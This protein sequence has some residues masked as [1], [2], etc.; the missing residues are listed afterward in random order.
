MRAMGGAIVAA[1]AATLAACGTTMQRTALI[2][3][4]YLKREPDNK[5]A[6]RGV[7]Y[8]LPSTVLPIRITG[9][10]KLIR[11]EKNPTAKHY[12]YL[13]SMSILPTK[14]VPDTSAQMLLEYLPEAASDDEFR[15]SVTQDGLLTSA[16]AKSTDRSKDVV[17]KLVEL[18]A[19]V[20]KGVS[21]EET[22][23]DDERRK[24]CYE[25]LQTVSIDW[26]VN[27][28]NALL[29]KPNAGNQIIK[30]STDALNET[31]LA[32]MRRK[33]VESGEKKSPV[34][35]TIAEGPKSATKHKVGTPDGVVFRAMTS[36]EVTATLNADGLAFSDTKHVVP[37]T[38]VSGAQIAVTQVMAADPGQTFVID[39][40]RT[41][42][43]PKRVDL[44]I[45]DGVLTGT[46][47]DKPSELL[48]GF[49]LPV[50]VL[51]AIV[52]IPAELLNFKITEMKAETGLTT[53]EVNA[54][55]AEIELLKQQQA[56]EALKQ[57]IENSRQPPQ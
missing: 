14:Q 3:T 35:M 48:A 50:E 33:T 20:M 29:D 47:V 57:E 2:E 41:P 16:K 21:D 12:E 39:T 17:L 32:A 37:C 55:K 51:K 25:M 5:P 9:E 4:E 56:L 19:L 23:K 43:V 26:S 1:A 15:I 8:F 42:F 45:S 31:L 11:E 52:S 36:R 24:A 49:S 34:A 28:S 18:A 22:P 38:L 30:E 13:L 6:I 27:I 44:T 7:P 10:F 46:E 40:S 53:E 54:L